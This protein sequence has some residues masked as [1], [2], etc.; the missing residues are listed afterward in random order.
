MVPEKIVRLDDLHVMDLHDKLHKCVAA[1]K[2]WNG[3][4]TAAA[5]VK[6]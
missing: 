3:I 4:P 1:I 6:A 5:A 2:Q